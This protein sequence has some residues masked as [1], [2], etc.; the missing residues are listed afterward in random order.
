MFE[1]VVPGLLGRTRFKGDAGGTRIE[2]L[3]L[4]VG[5]QQVSEPMSLRSGALLDV[6]GGEASLIVDGNPRR[7]KL[8]DVVPLSQNQII[9]I[10]NGGAT[11]PLLARLILLSRSGK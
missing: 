5:P 3:E 6:V 2:I 9:A 7:I 8:S 10:D 4:L 1:Q 11:R